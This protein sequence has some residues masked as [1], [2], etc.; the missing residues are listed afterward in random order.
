MCTY[1]EKINCGIIYKKAHQKQ[2]RKQNNLVFNYIH[3]LKNAN[4]KF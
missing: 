4:V 3:V 1:S 2:K